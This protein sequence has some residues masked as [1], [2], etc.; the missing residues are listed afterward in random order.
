VKTFAL[1]IAAQASPARG[2][3]GDVR[4]SGPAPTICAANIASVRVAS[5]NSASI[6]VAL[7]RAVQ[8]NS[9]VARSRAGQPVVEIDDFSEKGERNLRGLHRRAAL[10]EG[11][12]S[13]EPSADTLPRPWSELIRR[14]VDAD[15][16]VRLSAR[17][18]RDAPRRRALRNRR[19][20]TA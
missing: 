1:L 14:Q 12:N 16:N 6:A 17:A 4:R 20:T 5:S 19:S 8:R 7:I 11:H 9:L 10:L 2:H 15:G 3:L 13:L 18:R